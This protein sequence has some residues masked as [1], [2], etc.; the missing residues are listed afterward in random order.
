LPP[1]A[2]R[3]PGVAAIAPALLAALLG[4]AG[5]ALAS[6]KLGADTGALLVLFAALAAAQ[7]SL[8]TAGAAPLVRWAAAPLLL[9]LGGLVYGALIRGAEALL[10]GTPALVSPQPLTAL[11]LLAAGAFL[12][13]WIAVQAGLHRRSAALYVRVLGLSQPAAAAIAD[14]RETAHA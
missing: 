7:A 9:G 4:G 12:A 8:A 10:A 13:A 2:A 14:R 1:R 5:F 11:H 6:G 3:V